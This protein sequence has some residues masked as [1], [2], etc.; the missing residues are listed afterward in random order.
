MFQNNL[1]MVY[2]EITKVKKMNSLA[3]MVGYNFILIPDHLHPNIPLNLSNIENILFGIFPDATS[4]TLR[5]ISCNITEI[6]IY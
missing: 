1:Q 6:I 5:I 4:T 2:G 3:Y